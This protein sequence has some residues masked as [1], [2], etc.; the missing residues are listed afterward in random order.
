MLKEAIRLM[1]SGSRLLLKL[2][3]DCE[4]LAERVL[5]LSEYEEAYSE[6]GEVKEF[7]NRILFGQSLLFVGCSLNTD[8]T[9]KVM[10]EIVDENSMET[11]PRHYAFMELKNDCDRVVIK[12]EL[13]KA[14]IFPV[15]FPEDT[16]DESIEALFTLMQEGIL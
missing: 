6:A 15:W 12:R 2:H 14:N 5:L 3:G 16:H 10:K 9:I 7:L 1:S 4:T 11:L 8:R 13:A